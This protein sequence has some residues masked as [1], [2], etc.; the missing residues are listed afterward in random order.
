[1][2]FTMERSSTLKTSL[3]AVFAALA[4]FAAAACDLAPS[5]S[6]DGLDEFT[7]TPQQSAVKPKPPCTGPNKPPNKPPICPGGGN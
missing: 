6:L 1:M 7:N 4:V 3:S 5:A 2:L